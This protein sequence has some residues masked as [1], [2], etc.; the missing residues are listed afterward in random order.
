MAP[1]SELEGTG[2]FSASCNFGRVTRSVG[3]LGVGGDISSATCKPGR[4]SRFAGDDCGV[5]VFRVNVPGLN[6]GGLIG[7]IVSHD[8]GSVSRSGVTVS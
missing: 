1:F 2:G 8:S 4:E 6:G 5:S 3:G 7:E